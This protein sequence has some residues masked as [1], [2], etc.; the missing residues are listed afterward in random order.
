MTDVELVH[1]PGLHLLFG[2]LSGFTKKIEYTQD[3][4]PETA[5][6][7]VSAEI[8][9][10]HP[11]NRIAEV[12]FALIRED[13]GETVQQSKTG[14]AGGSIQDAAV[15][16][17]DREDRPAADHQAERPQ[18]E[19]PQVVQQPVE[20]Q[21]AV[22]QQAEEPQQAEQVLKAVQLLQMP[23]IRDLRKSWTLTNSRHLW[24]S[25]KAE[26]PVRPRILSSRARAMS[27]HRVCP[28]VQ[29]LQSERLLSRS[30]QVQDGSSSG[31]LLMTMMRSN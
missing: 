7:Q 13:T 16:S 4:R 29:R 5:F 28:R 1:V 31:D 9:N 25:T 30:L 6:L 18:A 12:S 10:D 2:G 11:E 24:L 17:G 20:P 14:P 15:S 3:G 27:V 21:Q 23:E 19:R 26:R 22:L 8:K